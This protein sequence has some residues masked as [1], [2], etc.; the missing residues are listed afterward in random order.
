MFEAPVRAGLSASHMVATSASTSQNHPTQS[1]VL[2]EEAEKKV[3]SDIYRLAK[4]QSSPDDLKNTMDRVM[5]MMK[6]MRI[7]RTLQESDRSI[8][9]SPCLSAKSWRASHTLLASSEHVSEPGTRSGA[10]DERRG[11]VDFSDSE[12]AM[13]DDE[14]TT[15][16][17]SNLEQLESLSERSSGSRA[18]HSGLFTTAGA[19]YESS[20]PQSGVSAISD[21]L[22][23]SA[24]SRNSVLFKRHPASTQSLTLAGGD[25]PGDEEAT[26][27]QAKVLPLV[28]RSPKS[29]DLRPRDQVTPK[30]TQNIPISAT[31]STIAPQASGHG[32]IAHGGSAT[33][34]Y[35]M[36]PYQAH[37]QANPI[38]QDP[39]FDRRILHSGALAHDPSTMGQHSH[40]PRAM[41]L[42]P[43]Y[44]IANPHMAY[45]TLFPKWDISPMFSPE[46]FLPANPIRPGPATSG[47]YQQPMGYPLSMSQQQQLLPSTTSQQRHY[48]TR[49]PMALL[50]QEFG[51]PANDPGSSIGTTVPVGDITQTSTAT[52]L[53]QHDDV[54][55][56][57][58]ERLASPD[59]NDKVEFH[60]IMR[61]RT[62]SPSDGT[63]EKF[64]S[65][66][67]ESLSKK[68]WRPL[69]DVSF[70]TKGASIPTSATAFTPEDQPQDSSVY[71]ELTKEVYSLLGPVLTT[72]QV[73]PAPLQLEIQI[74]IAT[75]VNKLGATE[76]SF[77]SF[78]ELNEAICPRGNLK[79]P[80]TVFF[81]RLTTLP[82]DIDHFFGIHVDGTRLF[83]S[84]PS[85]R[86]IDYEF[87]CVLKSGLPL[88]VSVD[89]KGNASI[90]KSK[91][92]LGSVNISFPDCIWDATAV[93]HGYIGFHGDLDPKVERAMQ[94]LAKNLWVEPNRTHVRLFTRVDTNILS[95][96]KVILRRTT[97]HHCSNDRYVSAID[98]VN[99]VGGFYL[100]ITEVQ[101]LMLTTHDSHGEILEAA[102]K[103]LEDMV[104]AHRQWWEVALFSPAIHAALGD[105]VPAIIGDEHRG[106]SP[107]DILGDETG[108]VTSAPASST[109]QSVGQYGLGSLLR[110]ATVVIENIDPVGYF[111]VGPVGSGCNK[112]QGMRSLEWR[113]S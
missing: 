5:H 55:P 79:G 18:V 46:W 25:V 70:T 85:I 11:L 111:N 35:S 83:E 110:L 109:A 97:Y 107:I 12:H 33:F 52:F 16:V 92:M 96:K 63:K 22:S 30:P 54:D 106:W 15:S 36:P 87:H 28:S 1:D 21:T 94:S 84:A 40:N 10:D 4:L 61:Q 57:I 67:R 48:S 73:F 58:Q 77:M 26:P 31:D 69:D 42:H 3:C 51:P 27:R 39:W 19:A 103:A 34:P 90:N 53:R 45:P 23:E 50:C 44:P 49:N 43:G 75:I 24:A 65:K 100:R 47:P 2:R 64:N 14:K 13:A 56:P 108:L 102:C 81:D 89:E 99:A 32:E 29:P 41:S 59:N 98:D 37:Y 101:E 104:K 76:E 105:G 74:G 71:P 20:V 9:P 93:L 7:S 86:T 17:S 66:V 82:A 88:V 62:P 95:V 80:S 113:S 91:V 72:A 112:R 38:P 78:E 6:E 60:S 68:R 8:A